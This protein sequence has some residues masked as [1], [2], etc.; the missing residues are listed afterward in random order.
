MSAAP[1]IPAP[2]NDQNKTYLPHSPERAE[3]K[4]RLE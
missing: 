4:A 3:L 2:Q 1:R